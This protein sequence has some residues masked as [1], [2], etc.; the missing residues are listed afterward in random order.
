[1]GIQFGALRKGQE[2]ELKDLKGKKLAIDA[3]NT[4]FQ[5]LSTI[6]DRTTG[7]PLQDSRGRITSHLSGLFYRTSKFIESGIKPV[8]VF[9]GP[10]P[11]FKKRV[12]EQRKAIRDEATKK[13]KEH[14]AKGEVDKAIK[15]AKMSTR[16][17]S[18]VIETSKQL[19]K[20]MGIPV[21]QAK[22]EG[23]AQCAYMNKKG[24]VWATASQDWDSVLFGS[25]KLVRNLST[26]GRRKIPGKEAYY[27]LKPEIVETK[28]VFS[29]LGVKREQLIIAAMLMGTDFNEGV[30]GLGP[31]RSLELIKK[32]KTLKNVLKIYDIPDAEE[33]YDLFL[34]PPGVD[35]EIKFEP[36]EPGKL[37]KFLVDDYEF[38]PERIDK[39]ISKLIKLKPSKH[40]LGSWIKQ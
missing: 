39:A 33:I 26:S 35:A 1:M 9:D 28:E 14:L 16:I 40:S 2:I 10:P 32:E 18:D 38:S 8:F 3:P 29:K 13:W 6:R 37:K 11:R 4:I 27:E 34:N 20:L 7:E 22:T 25:K 15:A 12:A 31:K 30:K 21:V 36:L 24:V 17:T 19:L 23:E 5:F